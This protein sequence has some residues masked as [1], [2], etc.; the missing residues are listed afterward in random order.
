MVLRRLR[1]LGASGNSFPPT[2]MTLVHVD[3]AGGRVDL[4][5]GQGEQLTLAQP[6]VGRGIGHQLAQV[7]APS[8]GQGPAEPGDVGIGG[9][10]GGAGEL[11]GF[12]GDA[13]QRA[14]RGPVPGLPVHLPQPG[15]GQVP[16]RDPRR[17]HGGQPPVQPGAL[18]GRGRGVDHLLHVG[19]PDVLAGHRG[20]D[21]GGEPGAQPPLGVGVLAG[22]RP[23]G[24]VPVRAQVPPDQVRAGPLQVRRV[25]LQPLGDPGQLGGQLL[26]G[27]RL[28][29]PAPA[30]LGEHRPPRLPVP[31]RRVHRDPALHLH[32]HTPTTAD[33]LTGI[34]AQ[35]GRP[36]R[37]PWVASP[38]GAPRCR[39]AGRLCCVCVDLGPRGR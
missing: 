16:G 6:A 30:V 31:L 39:T 24:R 25:S 32:H 15:V 35:A 10:L 26:L 33:G 34:P 21:R 23:I 4:A 14:R 11:R 17:D 36:S 27:P 9:D 29:V 8:G 37:R 28:P 2:S 20:D 18:P 13:H 19:D 1:P 22:P 3:D 7:P 38:R 5:G 12:P